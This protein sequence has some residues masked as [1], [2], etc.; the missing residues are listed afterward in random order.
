MDIDAGRTG[1]S[2][3]Y[4]LASVPRGL[5]SLCL[6]AIRE[7]MPDGIDLVL[8][9]GDITDRAQG[10][11]LQ[12]V[13]TDLHWLAN[14]L[15]ATLVATSGN[16]D[17]DSRAIDDP[18][19]YKS[20]LALRPEFP[21]GSRADRNKYFAEHHAVYTDERFVVI[22][23]NS[24]AHH[25]YA[26]ADA[27]EHLHGRY[28]TALP[29][30]IAES[31]SSISEHSRARIFLTHHHMSQ[32]PLLDTEERSSS[33]GYEDVLRKLSDFGP[34][35]VVHGHKHRGWMQYANGGGDAPPLL[36][37]ASFSADLGSDEFAKKVRHQFHVIEFPED[38]P[39]PDSIPGALGTVT[40]WTHGTTG[41]DLARSE[42]NLPGYSGFGWKAGLSAVAANL[43]TKVHDELRLD[44]DELFTIEPRLH[45]LLFDDLR[46]LE[47]L[48]IAGTPRARLLL[49]AHGR[50]A[51]LS[52][53]EGR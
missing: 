10:G 47:R 3:N 21:F 45:Y 32:L 26:R 16:H 2:M 6:N 17:Y 38:N 29:E 41:W 39:F 34:W 25:G 48:L 4:A 7:A 28:S 1:P 15:D 27:P 36:A 23:A 14:E 40:T 30:L 18:L 43:R 35:L 37:A 44:A 22:T 13:W 8:V 24:A 12:Q 53:L 9:A 52:L 33:I 11:P 42:E 5:L 46:K 51:E 20:L 31:L 49:D 50:I 19:P